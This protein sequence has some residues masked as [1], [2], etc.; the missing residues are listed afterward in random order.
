MEEPFIGKVDTKRTAEPAETSVVFCWTGISGYLSS[1]WRALTRRPEVDVHVVTFGGLAS[2][3]FDQ[4]LMEGIPSR[5]LG[6]EEREET[7]LIEEEVA[8]QSPDVVVIA[9]WFH[10]PYRN[11]AYS[12]RLRDARFVMGMDT[13]WEGTWRQRL[14]PWLLYRYIQRMDHVVVTGERCWQYARRL[15]VPADDITRGVYGVD[16]ASLSQ[17]S[18]GNSASE[19]PRRFLFVGRYEEEKGVDVLVDAYRQ[20]RNEV[21]NPWGLTC[22]GKGAMSDLLDRTAG[23]DNKGFVQPGDMREVW[24]QSGAFVLPSRFDPWPLALVEAAAAGLPVVCSDA[25][26][27][28]VEVVRHGYNGLK[29]PTASVDAL[30]QVFKRMHVSHHDLPDWGRRARQ[31]AEPYSAERWADRWRQI[32]APSVSDRA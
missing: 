26:G 7:T 11:L 20:Y 17:I 14:A 10:R 30:A 23:I 27:S 28:A 12:S 1:S 2:T 5:L 8:G 18:R 32:L 29:V 16:Y 9:G 19:W 24:K 31:F 3:D 25:C 22:C 15:G 21:D 4:A 6:E 13:P